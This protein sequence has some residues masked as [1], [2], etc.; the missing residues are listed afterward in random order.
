MQTE[1]VESFRLPTPC[2]ADKNTEA[3]HG[4]DPVKKE[5]KEQNST[6]PSKQDSKTSR[7]HEKHDNQPG[8]TVVGD[9]PSVAAGNKLSPRH[10]V[11]RTRSGLAV[12][13][14]LRLRTNV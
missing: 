5:G 9:D 2:P 12:S 6:S 1:S 3:T 7:R 4:M 8:C 13:R 10:K 14:S 11:I